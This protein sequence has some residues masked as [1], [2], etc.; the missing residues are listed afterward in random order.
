M[1][2]EKRVFF[3]GPVP[4]SSTIDSALASAATGL[5][6]TDPADSIA[7]STGFLPMTATLDGKDIQTGVEVYDESR[8]ESFNSLEVDGLPEG[9]DAEVAFR[10]SGDSLEAYCANALAAALA[11]LTGGAVFED[12]ERRWLTLEEADQYAKTSLEIAL[13]DLKSA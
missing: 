2:I 12:E 10:W 3:R 7:G 4:T 8:A 13:D 11:R 5:R 6:L 9:A 1:S